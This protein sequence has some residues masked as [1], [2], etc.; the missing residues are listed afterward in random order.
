[1]SPEISTS[2]SQLLLSAAPLYRAAYPHYQSNFTRDSLTYGLL[3]GDTESLEAQI[4]VCAKLQG[5]K[6][7][8]QTG[9]EL[10]KIHHESPGVFIND[11]YSTYNG[12]ET[13]AL[14]LLAITHLVRHGSI[15]LLFE[16]EQSIKN[17][18]RYIRS[19]INDNLFVEDPSLAG[20]DRFALRV[21][22]WKDSVL[23]T[24][25]DEPRYPIVYSLAHFQN[26]AALKAIGSLQ[27][28]TALLHCAERMVRTGIDLLWREDHFVVARE[29]DGSIVDS[30]STDSLHMLLYIDEQELP[31]GYAEKIQSYT[32]QLETKAGYRTGLPVE[33]GHDDYHTRYVWVHEQAL[34]HAAAE[35]HQLKECCDIT[36]RI[37]KYFNAGFPE[38][39]DPLA[40]FSHA[41]NPTQLW[42]IG[43]YM[44]FIKPSQSLI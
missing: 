25:H 7:D 18:V 13:T 43:A 19:H 9:E 17:A 32:Y 23:N 8:P 34:L 28:D 39:I 40:D 38:L 30:P 16:Y 4:A 27:N 44:Y 14:Y 31:I 35:K 1:M 29:R 20:A 36:Y 12:C 5:T 24:D 22:Y 37:M 10:G 41:G 42:C 33:Q 11:L 15:N 6:Q 2:L 3:A 21:T 26:A